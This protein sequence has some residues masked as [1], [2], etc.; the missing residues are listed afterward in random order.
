MK[1][2]GIS[3]NRSS[4]NSFG[5]AFCWFSFFFYIVAAA[6]RTK[7]C[8][9]MAQSMVNQNDSVANRFWTLYWMGAA[10]AVYM[11]VSMWTRINEI[12]LFDYE[13]WC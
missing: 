4:Y 8:L 11:P 13:V 2:Y 7:Q 5:T 12:L 6:D 1:A 9:T 3:I 10:V